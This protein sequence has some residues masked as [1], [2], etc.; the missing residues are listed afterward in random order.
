[1]RIESGVPA[2]SL[3]AAA[4]SVTRSTFIDCNVAVQKKEPSPVHRGV[5]KRV[6]Y[7]ARLHVLYLPNYHSSATAI[8]SGQPNRISLKEL[9]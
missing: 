2:S 6:H 5:R 7:I 4:G 3:G 1:M 8:V 9:T